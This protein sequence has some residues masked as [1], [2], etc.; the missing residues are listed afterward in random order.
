M[1]KFGKKSLANREFL[2]K[3]LKRLCDEVIK[4]YDFSIICSHRGQTE[5][6]EAFRIGNSNA[7]FGQSAHN[8]NPSFA[9]DVYPYPVPTTRNTPTTGIIIDNK[10][11]EWEKMVCVFKNA[12]KQL[13]ISITCGADFKKLKDYPHIEITDWK[14]KVK[15]I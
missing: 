1:P 4:Y 2:C 5:Q 13:G 11:P 14:D 6:E 8:Y 15:E 10:S 9:V 7:H 12:A 3:D